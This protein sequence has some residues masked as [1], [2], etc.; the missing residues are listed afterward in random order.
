MIV[1][2]VTRFRLTVFNFYLSVLGCLTLLWDPPHPQE[3]K[4]RHVAHLRDTF[5]T[6]QRI[7]T[8]RRRCWV[9]SYSRSPRYL[10]RCADTESQAQEAQF[11]FQQ[12][13]NANFEGLWSTARLDA[14]YSP[15]A[16]PRSLKLR[17]QIFTGIQVGDCVGD[18]A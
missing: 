6:R 4:V 13:Y 5:L 14:S 8:W 9:C 17:F 3:L 7:R 10:A 15:R 12:R 18:M 1:G 2:G 11:D 16:S